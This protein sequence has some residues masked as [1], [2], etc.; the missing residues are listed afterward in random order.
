MQATGALCSCL[1]SAV[2]S[3]S[4]ET[5]LFRR[6]LRV[7]ISR[8]R[9]CEGMEVTHVKMGSISIPIYSSCGAPALY[10]HALQ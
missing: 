2:G 1:G 7:L 8:D 6:V 9:R 4:A 10:R 3:L 5:E